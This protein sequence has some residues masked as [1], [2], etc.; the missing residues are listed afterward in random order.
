MSSRLDEH[1]LYRIRT[2]S[3]NALQRRIYT[4]QRCDK[5][6]SFIEVLTNK[7]T[8]GLGSHGNTGGIKGAWESQIPR[9]TLGDLSAATAAIGPCN[10]T[11]A[12]IH[13]G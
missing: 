9:G 3:I 4:I 11:A 2:M 1:N 10:S 7:H 5:L 6:Q 13:W 12:H 8:S